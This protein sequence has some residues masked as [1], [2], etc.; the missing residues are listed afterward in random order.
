MFE[1]GDFTFASGQKGKVKIKVPEHAIEEDWEAWALIIAENIKFGSVE[2][3][4]TGGLPLAFALQPYIVDSNVHLVVDDVFTT[5]G[6]L[7]KIM[8]A[9]KARSRRPCFGAVIYQRSGQLPPDVAAM[10]KHGMII[11]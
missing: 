7:K 6:S 11:P 4:P 5:G 1:R 3:V 10:W 2:G 9:F 8:D